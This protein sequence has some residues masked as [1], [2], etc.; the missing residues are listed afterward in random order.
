MAL[1]YMA[2]TMATLLL[3]T[4]LA[5]DAGRGYVVK[6][7]LTKAVDGAALAAARTLNSGTPRADA[8]RVFNANFP[9]GTLGTA[10][11]PDPTAAGDFFS[12]STNAATGINEVTVTATVVLPT[13]F[14][15][16]GRFQEI[17]VKS[18]GIANR[19]MV[20]LSLVVDVSG[21]LG[22]Q[23]PQVRDATREFINFFDAASD[24]MALIT[25]SYSGK[26]LDAMPSARGFNKTK[27]VN[28]VPGS[29]PGG[30][31]NT[32]EG[33]YRGW[34]ELRTVP[35][36]QQS[37]IRVIVLFTDGS[38]N[39]VPGLFDAT[40]V[41]KGLFVGDFPKATPDPDGITSNTPSIQGLYQTETGVRS[42]S[43]SI[44]VTWNSTT[45]L[46]GAQKWLPATTTQDHHRSSGIPTAFPLFSNAIKVDGM[47]QDA[48]R[49]LRHWDA[50]Q[51][52]YPAE[53]WNIRNAATNIVE[54]IANQ[55]R[56]DTT[57]DYKIR[58]YAIGMGDLVRMPLGTRPE[59]AEDVLKRVV[60]DKTSADFNSSQLE[61]KYYF[62]KTAADLG[63]AFQALQNQIIRL[64]K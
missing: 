24:R 57:G 12:L 30:V 53:A 22:S 36:G 56:N 9:P 37:G 33:L 63:G 49:G 2:V 23:W 28:D 40:G 48:V 21:S 4:G 34:D 17:T 58:I 35:A 20:D 41:A 61:G 18:A 43:V 38:A 62:A 59:K 51:G 3:V 8:V 44:S 26:V 10:V 39:T 27:L 19:R 46:S 6:A 42:P 7:Q 1:V 11:S 31:T 54:I 16:L 25:F 55:A 32:A 45:T 5:A 50:T 47:A 60:N 14:M 64:A 29:L 13:T 15:K 52:K